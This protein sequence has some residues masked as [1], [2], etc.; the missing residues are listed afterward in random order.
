MVSLKMLLFEHLR[1]KEVIIYGC[2]YNGQFLQW[3]LEYNGISISYMCD[4]KEEMW[5]KD[6][7]GTPC[8]SPKELRQ[9]KDA[10]IIISLMKYEEIYKM[11]IEESFNNVFNWDELKFLKEIMIKSGEITH[12]RDDLLDRDVEL[13]KTM[14]KN[15]KFRNRHKGQR[16]FI[17]G[18]GPSIKE[19]NL[20]LLHDEVTFTV[21]QMPRN[22]QFKQLNTQYHVWVD[23]DFFTVQEMC[24][25]DWEVMEL[26]KQMPCTTEC[27]FPYYPAKQYIEKYKINNEINVN[28]FS[29]TEYISNDEEIDITKWIAPSYTVVQC[30][31][32]IAIYMGF[33]E[34]YLLGCETTAILNII[35]TMSNNYQQN[36]HC[37]DMDE[38]EKERAKK[39]FSTNSMRLY[40]QSESIIHEDYLNLEQYCNRHGIKL[41]NCT[42]GG[43]IEN[44]PR[45]RYEQVVGR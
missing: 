32:R 42:P 25:G 30:A 24:E 26:M 38:K 12:Y 10:Y 17:I 14:M 31:I 6:Y 22:S 43:L 3:A 35:Y 29:T 36:T 33:S 44:L 7:N 1:G 45:E 5:G 37:Y 11:F 9:H 41:V 34:I 4:Q 16:C 19:Q 20:S 23:P 8:I 28:Y 40:F 21:N 13:K 39:M 2:G 15:E 27:F 18:N